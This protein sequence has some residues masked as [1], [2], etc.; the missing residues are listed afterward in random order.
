MKD[1]VL[2]L[3]QALVDHPDDVTVTETTTERG[4]VI[5]LSVAKGDIGKV[6]GKDGKTAQAIRTLLHAAC[7][8]SGRRIHLDIVD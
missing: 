3:A 8:R 5:K 6:I 2:V 4:S 7:N 1:L